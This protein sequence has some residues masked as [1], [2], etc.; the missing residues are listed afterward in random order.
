[1]RRVSG[2]HDFMRRHRGRE[3][4]RGRARDRALAR[5]THRAEVTPRRPPH[6][7]RPRHRSHGVH[8]AGGDR[9]SAH[10]RRDVSVQQ[11][12]ARR[13]GVGGRSDR[14]RAADLAHVRA[15]P[16]IPRG[17]SAHPLAH[18]EADRP[19]CADRAIVAHLSRA[20]GK[21][22]R[23][24]ARG[25]RTLLRDIAGQSAL[26]GASASRASAAWCTTMSPSGSGRRRRSMAASTASSP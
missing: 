23:D 11:S 20:H 12:G 26:G 4:R 1:M 13:G 18:L 9:G 2:K 3:R 19:Q 14:R 7:R 6:P 25:R 15:R 21:V 17:L 24:R 5:G 16:R 8:A 10:L 22:D